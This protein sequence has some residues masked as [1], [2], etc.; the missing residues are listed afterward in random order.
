MGKKAI[1][2]RGVLALD[3]ELISESIFQQ[4]TMGRLDY[5]MLFDY[6]NEKIDLIEANILVLKTQP[7]GL[8]ARDPESAVTLPDLQL[9]LKDIVNYQLRLLADTTRGLGLSKNKKSALLHYQKKRIQLEEKRGELLEKAQLTRRT[10]QNYMGQQ[11]AVSAQVKSNTQVMSALPNNVAPQLSDTFLDRIME[12]S[13][14]AS[15]LLI[16]KSSLASNKN[17][18]KNL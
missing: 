13:D 6:L 12:L 10:Y 16:D 2:E 9:R 7:N 11:Q 15:I 5:M 18:K 8:T 17:M 1:N 14:K 4:E 3:I